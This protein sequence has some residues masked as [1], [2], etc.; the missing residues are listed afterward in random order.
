MCLRRCGLVDPKRIAS[1]HEGE[2]GRRNVR[3]DRLGR[4]GALRRV[5]EVQGVR[6]LPSRSKL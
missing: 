3:R 1:E 5:A 2:H 4:G 6:E